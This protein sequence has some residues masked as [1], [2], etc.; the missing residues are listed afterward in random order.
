MPIGTVHASK[1]IKIVAFGDSLSSGYYL[2]KEAGFAPVLE[3]NL[4][5]K[6][7]MAQ[8]INAAIAG[9][10]SSDARARVNWMLKKHKPDLVIIEF[11]ANDMLMGLPLNALYDNLSV[12]IDA[13]Q[14]NNTKIL[15]VGMQAPVNSGTQYQN[16]LIQVYERLADEKKVELY[17][18]FL[19]DVA[20]VESLNLA[21]GLH[22]N[23]EGVL[24]IVNNILP[25]VLQLLPA[26]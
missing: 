19:K 11:G 2:P 1:M 16:Q 24:I 17:P 6:G 26:E 22:P 21:D 5:Q 9:E 25:S 18:F 8:V 13:I 12:V 23:P 7:I 10:T 4:Q 15:L 20:A 14:A 3:K